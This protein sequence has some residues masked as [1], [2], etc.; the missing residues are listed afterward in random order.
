MPWFDALQGK[1]W[2]ALAS[3]WLFHALPQP[4]MVYLDLSFEL[5]DL[6]YFLPGMELR[7]LD[8]FQISKA[9]KS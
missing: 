7:A 1:F 3:S 9:K 8:C 2:N 5:C 4:Q 6:P